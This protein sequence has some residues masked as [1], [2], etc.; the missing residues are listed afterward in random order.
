MKMK[1]KLY[2]MMFLFCIGCTNLTNEQVVTEINRCKE[3]DLPYAIYADS[4]GNVMNVVC[5]KIKP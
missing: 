1:L 4:F 5:G 3:N 2:C